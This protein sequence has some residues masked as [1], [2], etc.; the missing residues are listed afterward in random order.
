ML[1]E[2][3]ADHPSEFRFGGRFSRYIDLALAPPHIADRV[4]CGMTDKDA[5]AIREAW[6]QINAPNFTAQIVKEILAPEESVKYQEGMRIDA[7]GNLGI[8]TTPS[9]W[10]DPR[11]LFV[12]AQ[13]MSKYPSMG[14]QGFGVTTTETTAPSTGF[15]GAALKKL[16]FK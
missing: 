16:G 2:R 6:V 1:I 11:S 9:M 4:N 7:S 14:P 8:G 5:A 13:S 10:I 12:Q 3:M 15:G